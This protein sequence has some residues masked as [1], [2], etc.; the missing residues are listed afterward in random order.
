MKIVIVMMTKT[1]ANIAVMREQARTA[2]EKSPVRKI[3]VT[4]LAREAVMAIAK[5]AVMM[6]ARI[7]LIAVTIWVATVAITVVE[8]VVM[9]VVAIVDNRLSSQKLVKN[10]M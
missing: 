5:I 10:N 9:A 8:S 4:P 7:V 2:V 6:I 1:I 3:M